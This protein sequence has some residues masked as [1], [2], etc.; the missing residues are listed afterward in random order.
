MGEINSQKMVRK[1]KDMLNKGLAE[2]RNETEEKIN[3]FIEHKSPSIKQEAESQ[4]Q[5]TDFGKYMKCSIQEFWP[6][7]R[8]T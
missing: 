2:F 5:E 1:Y 4:P 6:R 3:A 8:P 7:W